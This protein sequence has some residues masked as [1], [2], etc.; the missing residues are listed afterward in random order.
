MQSTEP[1][2]ATLSQ[3]ERQDRAKKGEREG[4]GM[5]VSQIDRMTQK[6]DMTKIVKNLQDREK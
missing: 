3:T 5:K 4:Q 6:E 1:D 2:T